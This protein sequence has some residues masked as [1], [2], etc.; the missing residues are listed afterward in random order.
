MPS[1]VLDVE[2]VYEYI[3]ALVDAIELVRLVGYDAI[4]ELK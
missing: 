1:I 4:D 3:D 2:I